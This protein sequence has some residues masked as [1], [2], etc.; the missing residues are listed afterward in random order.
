MTSHE[1]ALTVDR[2]TTRTTLTTTLCT[3]ALTAGSAHAAAGELDPRFGAGGTVRPDGSDDGAVVATAVRPDGRIVAVATNRDII[4]GGTSIL[5]YRLMPDGRLDPTFDRDGVARI[6]VTTDEEPRD[7]ALAPDGKIVIAGSMRGPAGSTWD[8]V[9]YRLRADGGSGVAN[10]ALD[11]SFDGDG[12]AVLDGGGHESGRAIAVRPDGKI[13][14]AGAARW[15]SATQDLAVYRLKRDGGPGP[16]NGALDPTFDRDGAAGVDT[17]GREF[18]EDMALRPDGTI[19]VAGFAIAGDSPPGI[20]V[21]LR[22][23]GGDG[24]VNHALDPGFDVDG[25]AGIAAGQGNTV[26]ALALQQDGKVV[27]AGQVRVTTAAGSDG[28]VY[29]LNE[30]GGPGPINGALD[31]TFGRDGRVVLETPYDDGLY[32]LALQ[33]DG[34]VVA[35]GV[36]WTDVSQAVVYRLDKDGGAQGSHVA[37]DP[38]FGD[39]GIATFPHSAM[40]DGVG[41]LAL[42]PDGAIVAGGYA[43]APEGI[44]Q[45]IV[46]RLLG[47]PEPEPGETPGPGQVAAPQPSGAPTGGA[48]RDATGD[49]PTAGF[50]TRTGVTLRVGRRGKAGRVK[51]RVANANAF[52]VRGKLSAKG[53]KARA[54]AL[55]ARATRTI[56]L[57][58]PGRR[59]RLRV[60]ATVVDPAGH[61]RVVR[62]LSH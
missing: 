8:A 32:A 47:D 12:Y 41:T 13:V 22:P 30:G 62:G 4:R 18:A 15:F 21:Q 49:A 40:F 23:D 16:I 20:V 26:R 54:F 39:D 17:G 52:T 59:A 38:S 27:V 60:S 25:V 31:S 55:P 58:L 11:P 48:T 10:G 19:V 14:V 24:D 44:A 51:V 35:A 2:M 36:R 37:L 43:T 61:S 3:L 1:R 34:K 56:T 57:R 50:G 33:P 28:V 5:V 45:P 46:G 42:A 29:R 53:A 6:H 9:V 7:V